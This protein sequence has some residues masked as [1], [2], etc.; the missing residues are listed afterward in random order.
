M[1]SIL[2]SFHVELGL[3]IAQIV[4]FAIVF[5]VLYYFV[6]KP[7][8]KVM[9]ERNEKIQE[10]MKDA[11]RVAVK[12]KQTEADYDKK[13][14]EARIEAGKILEEATKKAEEKKD[15]I[16]AKSKEEIGII[17]TKEKEEIRLQKEKTMK[18][19]KSEISNIVMLS[20]EKILE[21]KLDSKEDGELIKK[22]LK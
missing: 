17:I 3:F 15:K 21:K 8:S 18:E 4:N 6:I 12:L 7:L 19:M 5:A 16:V 13:I 22:I 14:A 10:S 20:L 2:N 9:K 1:G 11:E